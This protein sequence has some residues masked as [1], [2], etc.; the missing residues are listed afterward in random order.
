MP[1]LSLK[2]IGPEDRT[3]EY[4][5]C[6]KIKC[7]EKGSLGGIYH[8]NCFNSLIIKFVNIFEM[9]LKFTQRCVSW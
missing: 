4:I 6:C 5:V 2:Q 1:H 7:V 9:G 3:R 8:F